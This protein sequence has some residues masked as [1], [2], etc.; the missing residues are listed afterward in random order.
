MEHELEQWKYL[1]GEF[2]LNFAEAE[3]EV[4]TLIAD[5][6]NND[7]FAKSK[8]IQ[9]K[10]R[11][12]LAIT[13]IDRKEPNNKY[14]RPII[15]ALNELIKLGDEVRNLIAHNPVQISLESILSND[16]AGEIRS[17]RVSEKSITFEELTNRN[18]E[19][20]KWGLSLRDASY[21]ARL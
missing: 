3:V 2:M 16:L 17:Y 9:F 4:F 10:E 8:R 14:K 5:H 11:A 18:N 1:I 12:N 19:L 6:G 15:R 13:I 21:K 20:R 7:D